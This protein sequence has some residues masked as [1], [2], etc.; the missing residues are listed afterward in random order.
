[1]PPGL[2][3]GE[4][5]LYA[6][7]GHGRVVEC[8]LDDDQVCVVAGKEVRQVFHHAEFYVRQVTVVPFLNVIEHISQWVYVM[9]VKC[10]FSTINLYI[11]TGCIA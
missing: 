8:I 11:V 2:Q 3:C 4:G 6:F 5:F 1:M 10:R 7:Y 9:E